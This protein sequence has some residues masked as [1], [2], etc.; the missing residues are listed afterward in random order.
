MSLN[1]DYILQ[2]ALSSIATANPRI[3][4]YGSGQGQLIA[5]GLERNVDIHGV[6]LPGI[7]T[8]DRARLLEEGRIPHNDNSF[9]VVVSNQVFEHV[10]NPPPALAEIRRVLKPGGVFLALFPDNTVWFEGHIGLYFVHWLM[11]FPALL[12]PYLMACHAAGLGYFRDGKTA[13]EWADWV[14]AMMKDEVCYHSGPDVQRW[15]S[16]TFGAKPESLMHDWMLFRI[17]ASP[18]LRWLTPLASQPWMGAILGFICR[19]R[20]GLVMRSRKPA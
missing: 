12:R 9:D 3:L 2:R 17:A 10:S 14:P 13:S 1:Y 5:L 15:W 20:A 6:D 7:E 4:D 18:R 19:V 11:P 16:E 8:N